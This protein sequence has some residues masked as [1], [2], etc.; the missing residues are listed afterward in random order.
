MELT[1]CKQLSPQLHRYC[2]TSS[3]SL[4]TSSAISGGT[5]HSRCRAKDP[6]SSMLY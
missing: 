4:R 6:V 1:Y 3:R 2:Y 5:C